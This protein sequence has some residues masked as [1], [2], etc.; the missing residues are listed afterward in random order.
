MYTI[1]QNQTYDN[2]YIIN[3]VI[4]E[5]GQKIVNFPDLYNL[6]ERVYTEIFENLFRIALGKMSTYK[7]AVIGGKAINNIIN[8]KYLKKSFDYDIH[9]FDSNEADLDTFGTKLAENIND[10]I[11]QLKLYRNYI[12]NILKRYNLITDKEINHYKNNILFYYGERQ[13]KSFNIKGIFFHFIFKDNLII[14]GRKYSN[15]ISIP[16][17]TNIISNNI[18][19]NELYYPLSD[20]DLDS[21]LNFGLVIKDMRYITTSYDNVKYASYSVILHNLIKYTEIPGQKQ[22]S[23]F[24]KLEN[25]IKIDRYTCFLL[26]S[27]KNLDQEINTMNIQT[28]INTTLPKQLY[29]DSQPILNKGDMVKDIIN[30]IIKKYNIDKDLYVNTCKNQLILD[31]NDTNKNHVFITNEK[32]LLNIFENEVYNQDINRYIYY[33]SGDGFTPINNYLDYNHFGLDISKMNYNN[34]IFK[35]ITFMDGSK[36]DINKK[37]IINNANDMKQII[38]QINTLIKTIKNSDA[39]LNNLNYLDDE[40]FVYRMQN[41]MC[42]NSPNGDQFNPSI[43]KPNTILY[44][45]RFL[46][47]SFTT[48]FA[49]DNF[50]LANTIILKI[51]LNKKSSNWIFLNKYSQ[52]PN[53]REIL[54]NNNVFFIITNTNVFPIN[55]NGKL[56]DMLVIEMS[57]VDNISNLILNKTDDIAVN[58]VNVKDEKINEIIIETRKREIL[59]KDIDRSRNIIIKNLN[60][61]IHDPC[62]IQSR[63]IDNPGSDLLINNINIYDNLCTEI[64]NSGQDNIFEKSYINTT[65]YNINDKSN[66]LKLELSKPIAKNM[67]HMATTIAPVAGGSNRYKFRTIDL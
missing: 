34:N 58:F 44:M 4:D 25:F 35:K 66:L 7:Y 67:A 33:Y 42:I 13:K 45:P 27:N 47:T 31:N 46:S 20:I 17:T 49:Y 26:S 54:I 23:N 5:N 24:Q 55:I 15:N 8:I 6:I 1:V 36:K 11:L 16:Q 2:S 64:I 52:Y 22:L 59:I 65:L 56:R 37:I 41:F 9:M 30:K 32:Q 50:V 12:I 40:F 29:I 43:L 61:L 10:T 63:Y 60:T 51:K 39:Y 21:S 28:K 48:N 18:L 19:I 14:D 57:L 53:E 62:I 3:D 38:T